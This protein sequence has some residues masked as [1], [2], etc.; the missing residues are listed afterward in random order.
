[1]KYFIPCS[2]KL[3]DESEPIPGRDITLHNAMKTLVIKYPQCVS[4]MEFSD[5]SH[6]TPKHVNGKSTSM[7]GFGGGE[8]G[9][10]GE[11]LMSTASATTM[12][13]TGYT[14]VMIMMVFFIF[15][16]ICLYIPG[17]APGSDDTTLTYPIW[18]SSIITT[19]LMTMYTVKTYG[20][21]VMSTFASLV[22]VF[23]LPN[24][25]LGVILGS[26]PGWITPFSNT[27]GYF[28]SSMIDGDAINGSFK[29]GVKDKISQF[30]IDPAVI[31]NSISATDIGESDIEGLVDEL[32]GRGGDVGSVRT[33]DGSA[34]QGGAGDVQSLIKGFVVRKDRIAYAVWVFLISS[35][36]ST[37]AARMITDSGN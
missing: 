10:S 25:G 2:T 9:E 8:S 34:Q 5:K 6:A 37:I 14:N 1:V 20:A 30:A 17:L 33:K 11:G 22:F 12:V 21:N 36:T 16:V 28:V 27:I 29:E 18:A 13:R 23:A 19:V 24:I 26:F 15:I 3:A 31:L 4:V 7:E 32:F 35:L